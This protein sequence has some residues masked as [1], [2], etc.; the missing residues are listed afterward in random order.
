LH[1]SSR[2]KILITHPYFLPA[3]KAGGPIQSIANLCRIMKDEY[4]FFVAC[5]D[6]D[7]LENIPLENIK[8]DNWNDFE[9]GAASV[10]YISSKNE[11]RKTIKE[12][13]SEV[14]PAYIFIN[15]I[16]S[17]N[18]TV[19]PLLS[20]K[21]GQKIISVRG[22]LHP[23]A[24]SQKSFKKKIYLAI[25]KILDVK[26]NTIFHATD[27]Q[28]ASHIRKLFGNGTK[29]FIAQN[30][31]NQ[32]KEKLSHFVLYGPMKLVSIALIS[33]MKNHALVLQAL[34]NIKAPVEYDIY[35]PVK[36]AVYWDQC[37]EI[38]KSLPANIKVTYKGSIAPSKVNDVLKN[39]HYLVQPSKS[40]NFGHAIYEALSSGLPVITSHF[41]PWNNLEKNNAGWNV[42]I[43]NRQSITTAFSKAIIVSKNDYQ[44]WSNSAIEFAG[45]NINIENIKNQYRLLFK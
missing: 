6:K 17:P 27:Q 35:G 24:L 32:V 11:K 41:T 39:Y 28:E 23:G 4:E 36:D 43:D 7:H 1:P 19:A 8:Q 18:F 15:G 2:K 31:P 33:P 34:N 40:E 30:L 26:K 20:N 5:S 16:Y 38:I 9:D 21:G 22:M 25:L 45:K 44:S 14:Q 13:I 10:F 37:L 12:I 42:D 3:Y 29:I